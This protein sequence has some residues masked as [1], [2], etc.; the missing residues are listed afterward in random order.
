MFSRLLIV[1]LA[2][3]TLQF[4]AACKSGGEPKADPEMSKNMLKMR[5]YKFT[6]EDFFKAIKSEESLLVNGFFDAGM[7]PNS[8][9]K[10]GLT[11]LT[12]AIQNSNAKTVRIIAKKANV[13]MK[14]DSGDGPLHLA[15]RLGNNEAID[16][17]LEAKADVNVTGRYG[18]VK[19]Q[20]PL[21]AALLVPDAKLFKRL[22]ELGADPNIA[23]SEGAF[24]LSE[25]CIKEGADVETVRLLLEHKADPNKRESNG[26]TSL[27]YAAQNRGIDSAMRVAILKLL[28]EKGSDKSLKDNT[29]KDALAWAKEVENTDAVEVLK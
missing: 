27:V 8:K 6:V 22:L 16:T 15:I 21:Y 9:N 17:L 26:A 3:G 23:D 10:N 19:N 4:G 29:G 20:S 12:Y 2:F 14:D 24:P 7:D 25:A 13:N 1:F 11:A 5:G 18:E 28:L